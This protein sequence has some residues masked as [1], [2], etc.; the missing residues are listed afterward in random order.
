M[1]FLVT[2]AEISTSVTAIEG[3]GFR[4]NFLA[5]TVNRFTMTACCP[6]GSVIVF[7]G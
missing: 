1:E 7:V 4:S 6:H 5:P 3:M 2:G